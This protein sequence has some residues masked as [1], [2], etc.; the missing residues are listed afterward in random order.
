MESPFKKIGSH[1]DLVTWSFFPEKLSKE[2]FSLPM[3]PHL[4]DNDLD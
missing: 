2:V 1:C 4:T 3:G